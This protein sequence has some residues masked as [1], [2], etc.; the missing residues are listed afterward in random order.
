[1]RSAGM[2]PGRSAIRAGLDLGVAVVD[3]KVLLDPNQKDHIWARV[4][5]RAVTGRDHQRA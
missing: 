3:D 5:Q 2:L 4:K 1:M